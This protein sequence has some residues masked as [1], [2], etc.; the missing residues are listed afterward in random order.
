M[1]DVVASASASASASGASSS[2][3]PPP[4]SDP[5]PLWFWRGDDR[6][7]WYPY[8]D[9]DVA[10]LEAALKTGD[11]VAVLSR[12]GATYVVDLTTA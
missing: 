10:A 2:D 3:P 1:T 5:P 12:G 4:P 8:D 11:D 9:S 7:S 6:S